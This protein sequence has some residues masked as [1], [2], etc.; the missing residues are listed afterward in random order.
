MEIKTMEIEPN[1]FAVDCAGYGKRK[2]DKKYY[3]SENIK[4]IILEDI[5]NHYECIHNID[6]QIKVTN[7]IGNTHL[8][9]RL[10]FKTY[11]CEDSK[12]MLSNIT[13]YL[14]NTFINS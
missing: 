3:E 7:N 5:F 12:Q 2:V 11:Q 8:D 9:I 13:D 6:G 10:F 4:N 14:N 1:N